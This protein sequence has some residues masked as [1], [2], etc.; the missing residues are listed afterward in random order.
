MHKELWAEKKLLGR[1]R[2]KWEGN[3]TMDLKEII[4]VVVWLC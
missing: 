1:T 4:E 2:H 3:V